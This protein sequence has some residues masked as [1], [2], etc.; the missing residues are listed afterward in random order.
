MQAPLVELRRFDIDELTPPRAPVPVADLGNVIP[1]ARPTAR[2]ADEETPQQIVAVPEHRV[3]LSPRERNRARLLVLLIV[4]LLAHA[5]LLIWLSRP[6]PPLPGIELAPITV[7]IIVS[8][9][10]R[11]DT[12]PSAG[13]ATTTPAQDNPEQAKGEPVVTPPV[14]DPAPP[15]APPENEVKPAEDQAPPPAE[16]EPAPQPAAPQQPPHVEAA[17][18]Q[19]EAVEP[20]PPKDQ[21]EQLPAETKTAPVEIKPAPVPPPKQ[22]QP[23]PAVTPKQHQTPTNQTKRRPEAAPAGRPNGKAQSRETGAKPGAAAPSRQ[24]N[25]DPNYRGTAFAHL[26]RFK[27]MPADAQRNHSQGTATVSFVVDG[28]GRVGAVRLVRASGIPSLDQE[29]LAWPRRASPFPPPPGGRPV[30]ITAPLAFTFRN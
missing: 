12:S 25:A 21:I 26:Q 15:P 18:P 16:P 30:P 8:D 20:A 22:K 6:P 2:K 13:A 4:S 24:S 17:P 27:R 14:P 5:A 19:P 7:E 1:F 23:Q 3:Q 9:G 11:A 28:S 10:Q 29:A